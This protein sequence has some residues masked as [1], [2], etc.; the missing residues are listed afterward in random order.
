MTEKQPKCPDCGAMLRVEMTLSPFLKFVECFSRNKVIGKSRRTCVF[1]GVL[2]SDGKILPKM[3]NG[4]R[5]QEKPEPEKPTKTY[6]PAKP[7]P[8]S[9]GDRDLDFRKV[10]NVVE[11]LYKGKWRFIGKIFNA[12]FIKFEN[13]HGLHKK[14]DSF[15][16]PHSF[17]KW[18]D[19]EKIK[20]I[21]IWY[22][23][24]QHNT[25]VKEWREKGEF[26][27]FKGNSEKRVHLTRALF[28]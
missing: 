3:V 17:L 12:E 2:S 14:T 19:N 7:D 4:K 13:A 9:I 27:Y 20:Y 10:G 11:I 8:A 23:G 6:A 26:L 28:R 15:G 25:T 1:E 18:L 24:I 22:Q 16:M 21:K 5:C